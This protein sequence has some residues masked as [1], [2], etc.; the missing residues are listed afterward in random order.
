MR[1]CKV[2]LHVLTATN[3]K[4]AV[5]CDVTPYSRVDT[6]QHFRGAYCLHCRV[7]H[8][9]TFQR[10]AIFMFY[11]SGLNMKNNSYIRSSVFPHVCM[12]VDLQPHHRLLW[13]LKLR[14]MRWARLVAR[15]G[16]VQKNYGWKTKDKRPLKIPMHICENNIKMDLK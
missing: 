2:R 15:M 1:L 14:G 9:A 8:E 11:M 7:Y 12:Y 13:V 4:M 3:M 10:A 5:F 6:D 16:I